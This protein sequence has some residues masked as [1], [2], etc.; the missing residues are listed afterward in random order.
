MMVFVA[1]ILTAFAAHSEYRVFELEIEDTDKGTTRTVISTFDHL[2]YP[3]YY[4][5][6]KGE[7]AAYRDSWMC[8]EN[9]GN[10]RPACPKPEGLPSRTPTQVGP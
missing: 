4:P 6:G 1:A 5:L 8:W 9:M 3:M 2:Q 10:L 7:V